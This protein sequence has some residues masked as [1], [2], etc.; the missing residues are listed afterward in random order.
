[1]FIRLD[2]TDSRNGHETG[3]NGVKTKKSAKRIKGKQRELLK[4]LL[5][6]LRFG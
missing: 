2:S 3:D 6:V 1:M 5:C 4:Y